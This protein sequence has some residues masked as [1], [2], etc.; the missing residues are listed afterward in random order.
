MR[1]AREEAHSIDSICVI[2][3]DWVLGIVAGDRAIMT[4]ADADASIEQLGGVELARAHMNRVRDAIVEYRAARSP[5]AQRRSAVNTLVATIV[6]AIGVGLL[7][8]F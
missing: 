4:I 3:A 2:D 6:F 8:W 7:L 5:V 1:R